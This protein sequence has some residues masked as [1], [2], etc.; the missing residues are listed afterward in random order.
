MSTDTAEFTIAIPTRELVTANDLRRDHYMAQSRDAK[1]LLAK[2]TEAARTIGTINPP[3]SV[4]VTVSKAHNGRWDIDNISEK[5]VLDGI[6]AA[7]VIPDD[8]VKYVHRVT[9]EVGPKHNNKGI[10]RLTVRV[11]EVG[12][13]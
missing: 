12:L 10:V 3:V 5:R 1:S 2:V 4:T 6:V 7:G 9:K 8:S 13:G 11:E